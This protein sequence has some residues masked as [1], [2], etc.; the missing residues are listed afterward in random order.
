MLTWNPGLL[1]CFI[2][3]FNNIKKSDSHFVKAGLCPLPAEK[4]SDQGISRCN[5][6]EDCAS[7]MKCCPTI[8]GRQ[9]MLPDPSRLICPDKSIA[10][11]TCLTSLDCP[12]NRQCYQFVC[13]PGV[14]NGIKAGKCPALIVPEGWKIVNDNKC[15]ADSDCPGTRKCCPTLLGKRCLVPI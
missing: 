13:C 14:P 1:L 15:Q 4:P 2:F 6:D 5:W 7:A 8:L 10:D 11:R 12:A 9:C 3:F